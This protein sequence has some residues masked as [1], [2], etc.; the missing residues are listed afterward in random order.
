MSIQSTSQPELGDLEIL[1]LSR[2][3]GVSF[4]AA[5]RRCEDLELLPKG[6]A[7]SL[8]EKLNR[9]FGS[10]EQRAKAVNLPERPFVEFPRIPEQLLDCRDCGKV[11]SGDMSVGR[12]SSILGISIA[13]LIASNSPTV[14]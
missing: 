8:E 1:L 7:A 10:P 13:D 2:I 9:E 4:Y 12:V 3:Y 5:A 14:H 11:K 6:G